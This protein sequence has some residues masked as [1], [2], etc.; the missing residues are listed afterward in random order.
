MA[1]DESKCERG[2][3][4]VKRCRSAVLQNA[5]EEVLLKL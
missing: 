1:T 3:G 5:H 4:A 2:T